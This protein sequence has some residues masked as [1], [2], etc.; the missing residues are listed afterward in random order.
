[1]IRTAY[2]TAALASF[3]VMAPIQAEAARCKQGQVLRASLGVCVSKAAAIRAGVYKP[4]VK[5]RPPAIRKSRIARSVAPAIP[6]LRVTPQIQHEIHVRTW[7]T[8]ER[9]RMIAETM[10]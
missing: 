10:P 5:K 6:S 1:V 3:A 7:L 9:R 2:I 8:A 4:R